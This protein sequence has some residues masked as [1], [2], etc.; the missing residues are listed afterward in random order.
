MMESFIPKLFLRVSRSRLEAGR[1]IF[2]NP[3]LKVLDNFRLM[4][5]VTVQLVVVHVVGFFSKTTFL[6]TNVN[7]NN[8]KYDFRKSSK[9]M[10]NV[11]SNTSFV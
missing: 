4:L 7:K 9:S 5:N 10:R 6:W 11:E 3:E 1:F 8:Q 2:L